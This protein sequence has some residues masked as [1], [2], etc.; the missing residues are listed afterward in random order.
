MKESIK[1]TPYFSAYSLKNL[2]LSSDRTGKKVHNRQFSRIIKRFG[3]FP[4]GTSYTKTTAINKINIPTVVQSG[5]K[6][7]FINYE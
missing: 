7:W 2:H 3:I 1:S 6:N 5:D 4:V